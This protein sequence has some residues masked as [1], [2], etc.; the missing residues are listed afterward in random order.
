MFMFLQLEGW[1]NSGGK[2]QPAFGFVVWS[3]DVLEK[4]ASHPSKKI[5][6]GRW[7]PGQGVVL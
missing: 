3:D 2:Q 7:I 6:H 1:L 4:P 5:S